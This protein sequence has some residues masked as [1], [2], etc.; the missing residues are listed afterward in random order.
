MKSSNYSRVRGM[1]KSEIYSQVTSIEGE[2]ADIHKEMLELKQRI[3]ALIEENQRLVME[4]EQLLL[5][6]G[7]QTEE[8]GGDQRAG[9]GYDNLVRIYHEGFHVCNLHFGGLRSEGDCLFC[10]SFLNK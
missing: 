4:N 1:S 8:V 9:E 6:I 5:Q 2:I 7:A 10:L 3:I